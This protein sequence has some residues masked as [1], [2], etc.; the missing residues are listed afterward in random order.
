MNVLSVVG[1]A[2]LLRHAEGATW[3][4]IIMVRNSRWIQILGDF[5]EINAIIHSP[6]SFLDC[7]VIFSNGEALFRLSVVWDLCGNFTFSIGDTTLRD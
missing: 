3:L 2:N 4:A 7:V 5:L 6:S 1:G